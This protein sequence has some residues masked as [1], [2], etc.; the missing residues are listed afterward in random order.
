MVLNTI[1]GAVCNPLMLGILLIATGTLC[2]WRRKRRGAIAAGVG[3]ALWFWV[4][5]SQVFYGVLGY[6]LEK[7]F[8]PMRADAMPRAEVIVILGG[9]MGAGRNQPYAEMWTGADRVWHAA[10][11]YHAGRAPLIIPSGTGEGE[12]SVPL[13]LDLGVPAQA[14]RPETQAR[15]TEENALNVA[16]MVRALPAGEA[17]AARRILLVT[18]AGHMRRALLN[19]ERTGLVVIPAAT[20]HEAYVACGQELEWVD[21]LPSADRFQRNSLA[22]KEHLGYWLYRVKYACCGKKE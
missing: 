13:L 9:G 14:I 5:G 20:D 10:R 16:R 4:W 6:G 8:P 19:F 17:Q 7:Q 18:S 1:V 2:Q 12:S 15:N 21:F 11:L 3:A 22:F